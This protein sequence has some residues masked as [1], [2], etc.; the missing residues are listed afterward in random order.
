LRWEVVNG[1]DGRSGESGDS[2]RYR[3]SWWW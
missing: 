3:R 1:G 2:W